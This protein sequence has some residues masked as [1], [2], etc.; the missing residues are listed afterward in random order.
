VIRDNYVTGP[1]D[2]PFGTVAGFDGIMATSELPDLQGGGQNDT[3]TFSVATN[4]STGHLVEGNTVINGTHGVTLMGATDCRVIGNHLEGQTHRGVILSP[5]ALRNVIADNRIK[6]FGSTAIH[7]AWGACLNTITGNNCST[8]VSQQEMN[9]IKGYFGCSDNVVVGNI[10]DG[11]VKGGI[12]FAMG[13]A[14]NSVV[15][16]RILNSGIGVQ[17]QAYIALIEGAYYQPLTPPA[18]DGNNISNN[19]ISGCAKGIELEAQG[20]GGVTNTGVRGNAI[21][22]VTTSGLSVV[23][24]AATTVTGLTAVGNT[25]TGAGTPWVL[26]RAQQHFLQAVANTGLAATPNTVL[27]IVRTVVSSP[28]ANVNIGSANSVR[29]F[30]VLEGG[31][32]TKIRVGIAVSS[33]NIAVAVYANTGTGPGAIPGVRTGTSGSIA[34]P[35]AG[36][37]DVSLGG[38]VV[39]NAGDWLAI[40]ADNTTATFNGVLGVGDGTLSAGLMGAQVVYPPPSPA[41]TMVPQN[42]RIIALIGVP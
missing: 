24:S 22:G 19:I 33:G 28:T 7:L 42:N 38:S 3:L 18:A 30:R 20:G 15:G 36:P 26:P 2:A 5:I 14:R 40:G 8:T 21:Q 35:A 13:S 31:A 27:G 17:I 23:E 32:I 12:R 16:N 4:L 11:P 25:V 9:G 39:V 10:V 1:L 37:Q 29:Y 41:G 34:C 6:D